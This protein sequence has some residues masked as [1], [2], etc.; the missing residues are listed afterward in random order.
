[1]NILSH[2]ENQINYYERELNRQQKMEK[3]TE[4]DKA[5]VVV[6]KMMIKSL[7]S[8]EKKLLKTK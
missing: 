4:N 2:I 5:Y 1:M 8:N 3:P 6:L 7:R